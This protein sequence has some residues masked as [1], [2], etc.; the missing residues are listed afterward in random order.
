MHIAVFASH[1]GTDLQAILDACETGA[2]DASVCAVISNNGDA[3]ALERAR[4]AGVAAYHVSAKQ[5][6]DEATLNDR[7]LAIL[8]AHDTDVVFLAGYL[9]KLGA[10]V[11]RKYHNRVFNIHPALLPKYGGEGMY[12]IHVHQAVIDA[13]EAESGVTIHRANEAYDEGEIVGQIKVPVSETD[14]AATLAAKILK[15]EHSFIVE[16]LN[17]IVR[18]EIGI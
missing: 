1:N 15:Q 12:G 13:R 17:K 2:L 6:S 3:M 9:K 7:I 4:K 5:Y 8:D 16:V 14:T 18:G 10:K 11:L